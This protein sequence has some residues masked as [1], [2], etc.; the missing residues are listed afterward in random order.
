MAIAVG[1]SSKG[2]TSGA[3]SVSTTGVATS[4][5]GSIITGA[6][7]FQGTASATAF[8]DNK[9]N[10][11]TIINAEQTVDTTN[12]AKIRAYYKENA[13]GGAGHTTTS[14]TTTS[15]PQTIAMIEITGAATSSALATANGGT[16]TSSPYGNAVSITPAAGNYLLVAYFGGNSASNPATHAES[17]G[18]TIVANTNE[19]NGASL[20]TICIATKFVTAD[21]STP[22]TAQFTETGASQ[23]GVI[24]AAFKEA[25]AGGGAVASTLMMLG[26]GV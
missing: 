13:A 14:H 3:T 21:G 22:Y 2:G 7:V 20:W 23:G 1:Q 10:T 11:Y 9:S 6:F 4:A 24:I 18:F 5:T 8:D 26:V 17:Q 19:T 12:A 15:Q 25:A 16:D